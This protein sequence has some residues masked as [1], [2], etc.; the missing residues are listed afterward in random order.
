MSNLELKQGNRGASFDI[1]RQKLLRKFKV[2]TFQHKQIKTMIP[3][4][5]FDLNKKEILLNEEKIELSQ[6][7]MLK[8]DITLSERELEKA[9]HQKEIII[10][11]LAILQRRI[12]YIENEINKTRPWWQRI[13]P[14]V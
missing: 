3:D 11:D 13:L 12:K 4:L 10:K 14:S 9:I 1:E 5:L 8:Y 7:S 2:L 6:K